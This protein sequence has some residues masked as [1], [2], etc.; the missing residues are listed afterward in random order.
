MRRYTGKQY[1]ITAFIG[2]ALLRF[3]SIIPF[4]IDDDEAWWAVSARALKTPWEFYFRAVD[5]KPPGIVW[6]YYFVDR[7]VHCACDPRVTRAAFI[8]LLV[9]AALC[10]RWLLPRLSAGAAGA[11]GSSKKGWIAATL[12]VLGTAMGLP[13]LFTITGEGLMTL[14]VV[15]GYSLAFVPAVSTAVPGIY[16]L[17]G[18]LLGCA[19]LV[20]QTAILFAIPILFCRF[21]KRFTSFQIGQFLLGSLLVVVPALWA[22]DPATFVYWNWTYPS[23]VLISVRDRLFD[24]NK[25]LGISL[26]LFGVAL[27]PMIQWASSALRSGAA[28]GRSETSAPALKALIPDWLR[29]FRVLWLVSATFVMLVGRGLFLHYFVPMIAP[30]ALLAAESPGAAR[31]KSFGLKWMMGCYGLSAAFLLFQ[32]T[33]ILWT[34]DLPYFKSVGEVIRSNVPAD[35]RILVWGGS[36][37]PLSYSGRNYVTRFVVP[38][39]GTLPYSTRATEEVFHRELLEDRPFMIVDLHER[40]DNRF[41]NPIESDTVVTEM[42]KQEFHPYFATRIPWAKF[43]LREAPPAGSEL[44]PVLNSAALEALSEPFPAA[45]RPWE[46]LANPPRKDSIVAW[47]DWERQVR[48]RYGAE[49]LQAQGSSA[50][51]RAKARRLLRQLDREPASSSAA[52]EMEQFVAQSENLP[53][54]SRLWW[55]Q[56]AFVKLT[57]KAWSPEVPAIRA[58]SSIVPPGERIHRE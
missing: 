7:I 15:A 52:D 37:L 12:F 46:V 47:W 10:L 26:L 6:F 23:E 4:V 40:A 22:V 50:E 43:Y 53:T 11:A 19:I 21:P 24:S 31:E 5:V 32:E 29:D 49:L 41:N 16:L 2:V 39:F 18:A 57:P 3:V 33:G 14:F 8:L 58:I 42:I 38:R 27:F 28:G 35:K 54:R 20:K 36:T 56:L 34:T 9:G 1:W 30:L 51:V 17:S 44:R 48:A 13:K 25:Q 55:L 45:E